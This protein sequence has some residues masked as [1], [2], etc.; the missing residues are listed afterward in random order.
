MA[1]FSRVSKYEMTERFDAEFYA[2]ECIRNDKKLSSIPHV[3]L[4]LILN[5]LQL[6]YTGPTEKYYDNNGINYLS[7]KNVFDGI[8]E[9]TDA[10]DKI[11]VSAHRNELKK[12]AVREGDILI[13]RTGTVGKSS[14]VTKYLG[15]ANIA[16][17][18][19]ALRIIKSWD[20]YYISSFLNSS[21]GNVQSTRHQRGT[22]IQG[23]SVYDVPLFIIPRATP[24]VQKYIGDKIRQAEKLRNW[25]KILRNNVDLQLNKLDLPINEPPQMLSIVNAQTLEDRLDPRPYRSHYLNLA[26]AIEG[27][28]HTAVSKLTELAS[29]CPVSSNDFIENAGVPLVRIR[30]IGFDDF[31]G[32]DTGVNNELYQDAVRYHAKEAMIVIGMD[33]NFRAQFFVADELPMLVNQR[34][35]MLTPKTIR[36]ELLTHWLNRPEGQLQ[37]NQWAVK[38][39]VEHTSLADIGRIL[40]PRLDVEVEEQCADALLNARLAYRYAKFL[41]QTAK[42]LVEAVIEDQLAEDQLIQAQQALDHGDNSLDRTV[43]SKLSLDGYGVKGAKPLFSDLDELYRLLERAKAVEEG[44][45]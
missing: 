43:L 44:D 6:G 34:V 41:T 5:D 26:K 10:T 19:I 2:P 8:I 24:L 21:H 14:V 7:S 25:A 35:A 9:I 37:L 36:G 29:G 42:A 16:A 15:E 20:S 22:I 13:S 33:G 39:T 30:N 12:T 23:L 4:S 32:L 31:I 45:I 40:I 11:S 18:L 3:K 28:P 17:H 38:T 1:L 27:L